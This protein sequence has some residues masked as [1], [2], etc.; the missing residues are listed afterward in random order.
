[1]AEAGMDGEEHHPTASC[2]LLA[3]H[4]ALSK[5]GHEVQINPFF[6]PVC[7]NHC[8][9]FSWNNFVSVLHRKAKK[10]KEDGF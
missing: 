6:C 10:A 5:A 7:I 3:P 1:M 9:S 2:L 4:P 8:T